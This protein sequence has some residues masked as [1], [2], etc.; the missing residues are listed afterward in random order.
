MQPTRP[1][2]TL[3][4]QVA[5][6]VMAGLAGSAAGQTAGTRAS[7][8]LPNPET[9][10]RVGVSAGTI[11]RFTAPARPD[12]GFAATFTLGGR[13]Y[14]IDFE[15]DPV[16][17]PGCEIVIDDGSGRLTV[18]PAP[19]PA[20]Y[21]GTV[22]GVPEGYASGGLVGG[23]FSGIVHLGPEL[24]TWDV[25]PL[26]EAQPGAAA[27]EH[28]VYRQDDQLPALWTCALEHAPQGQRPGSAGTTGSGG[29]AAWLY[30]DVAIDAD[31]PYFVLNGSNASATAQDIAAVLNNVSS[32]YWHSSAPVKF[33]VV[34]Y[35]I[36]TT[37]QGNPGQYNSANPHNMLDGL[38]QVWNNL[39]GHISRDVTH[40]FTG[41]DLTGNEIGVAYLGTV[42]NTPFAY[43][44]SQSR[45]SLQPGRRAALT[46]HEL[47]HNFNANHC[48]ATGFICFPCNIMSAV[49]GNTT[50]ALTRLGCSAGTIADFAAGRSC[51]GN[52]LHA[53]C[54][55]DMD[56]DGRATPRDFSVFQDAFAGG[57]PRA[58]F[59]HDGRLTVNDFVSYLGAYAA[60]CS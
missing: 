22:R 31:Y 21:R 20:T 32:Y 41:V 42:C 36:R 55:A 24:G 25:L 1:S 14:T 6:L 57:E 52:A 54:A 8:P 7:L 40:L 2:P 5:A 45:F 50:D 58:D 59:D 30:C 15:L 13:A 10:A 56:G 18:L 28:L 49:Q 3:R 53:S 11:Q 37:P 47:G 34:R 9:L 51:I 35:L 19:A 4:L 12:E 60:G 33:R 16:D 29:D 38:R 39:A 44:L 17:G 46:A 48:D 27:A 26:S 43:G 23:R